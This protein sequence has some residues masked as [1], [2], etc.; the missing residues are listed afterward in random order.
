MEDEVSELRKRLRDA[1][2]EISFRDNII[3]GQDFRA[4]KVD[5]LYWA[6]QDWA[7]AS[8]EGVVGDGLQALEDNFV[9]GLRQ[10]R[11]GW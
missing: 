11:R 5:W 3:R 10:W 4:A 7:R 9:T 1:E 2:V 8:V 6:Y